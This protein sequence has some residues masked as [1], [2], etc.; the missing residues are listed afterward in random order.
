VCK[1]RPLHWSSQLERHERMPADGVLAQTRLEPRIF[2]G[3]APRGQPSPQIRTGSGSQIQSWAGPAF[4]TSFL[5]RRAI[6]PRLLRCARAQRAPPC[7][8]YCSSMLPR[9]P[10]GAPL[11]APR[12]HGLRVR[13]ATK[14]GEKCRLALISAWRPP[15]PKSG[16]C[17]NDNP[18]PRVVALC[19]TVVALPKVP[20]VA[21]L[22]GAR[23]MPRQL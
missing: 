10:K 20:G 5:L 22:R 9:G 14:P 2:G 23:E 4:L 18:N 19:A 15:G 3:H 13:L 11:R 7:S 12:I 21:A 17:R 6:K 16:V 8:I 1:T